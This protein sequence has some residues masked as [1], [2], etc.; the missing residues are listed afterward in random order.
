[1][2]TVRE[3]QGIPT[4]GQFAATAHSEAPVSLAL[5]K[6]DPPFPDTQ[7]ARRGHDFFPDDVHTWPAL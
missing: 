6:Q 2:S 5:A 1:M 3:P 4:G 7:R